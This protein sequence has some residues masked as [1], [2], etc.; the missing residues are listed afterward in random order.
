MSDFSVFFHSCLPFPCCFF[1]S[2]LT[3]STNVKSEVPT[4]RIEL[5]KRD[6]K[7]RTRLFILSKQTFPSQHFTFLK[8]FFYLRF[9]RHK[10]EETLIIFLFRVCLNANWREFWTLLPITE[11][12]GLGQVLPR[13]IAHPTPKLTLAL[14]LTLTGG[15]FS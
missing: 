5:V 2:D 3:H 4:F 12:N 10:N 8:Q 9:Y 11:Y 7:S 6:E 14:T 15:Q 13:K 1:T